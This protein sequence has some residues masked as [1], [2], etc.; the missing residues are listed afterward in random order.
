MKKIIIILS[1]LL[2]IG[3]GQ[4][5]AID[6]TKAHHRYWYYRHRL[7]NDFMVKW[8]GNAQGTNIPASI[9]GVYGDPLLKWGDA[10]IDLGFYIGVLA[11]EY[12]LLKDNGR[13]SEASVTLLDLR[14]ALLA[15][16]RLDV[17]GDYQFGVP[18]G[19]HSLNGFMIRD[20]VPNGFL[21]VV[22]N[23]YLK[24]GVD[25]GTPDA[26]P[27]TGIQSD[28]TSSIRA[29]GSDQLIY[30][31]V[32]LS[33]VKEYV[34]S[35]AI[36]PGLTFA[37]YDNSVASIAEEA[38]M[39]SERIWARLV[40]DDW[41]L[42]DPATGSNI[43]NS[44]GGTVSPWVVPI[45]KICDF[46][47]TTNAPHL[48]PFINTTS[49]DLWAAYG[50]TGGIWPSADAHLI[51][52]LG[53]MSN[54]FNIAFADAVAADAGFEIMPLLRQ[55]LYG[56]PNLID[57]SNYETL[58]S[59]APCY[60][61]YNWIN[62]SP[63]YSGLGTYPC[64]QWS[65]TQRWVHPERRHEEGNTNLWPGQYN[66]LDYML[67]HNLFY[68]VTENYTNA[69]QMANMWDVNRS[70]PA[71]SIGTTSIPA[72]MHA[73]ETMYLT[74]MTVSPSTPTNVTCHAGYLLCMLSYP[75]DCSIRPT[76]TN[77]IFHAYVDP[78]SCTSTTDDY[79]MMLVD[80]SSQVHP[81]IYSAM[82][83][84]R[85]ELE[86]SYIQAHNEYIAAQTAS[87]TNPEKLANITIAPNPSTGIF[88]ISL[89]SLQSD[90]RLQ[91]V[92]IYDLLGN[93]VWKVDCSSQDMF[94]I[95]LTTHAKGFYLLKLQS[96][97]GEIQTE[98]IIYK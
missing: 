71:G 61:P 69:E 40:E 95:D 59:D 56:G 73:Y 23:E 5:Q 80:T 94:N 3:I 33:L 21:N 63:V 12:K 19:S 34:P 1:G 7:Q 76:G 28:F 58:I 2:S 90:S 65:S 20:D 51:A 87:I 60:G 35:S 9:R 13:N 52:A 27:V 96:T 57:N 89:F 74:G 88:Q 75:G 48:H 24:G 26:Y 30:I 18:W 54:T 70:F 67:L 17:E 79:H 82:S 98:K 37:P 84:Q 4:T 8:S 49:T 25:G 14:Y 16:N 72:Q 81:I 42:D 29:V 91:N 86:N 93:E 66:G 92:V 53:N 45:A 41:T 10:T 62:H 36:C 31:F 43:P 44:D 83:N 78:F 6:D 39:I 11:T 47:S 68:I 22:G 50:Q 77:A 64:N 97:T 38:E 46:I 55:A 85:P 32:G 15:L